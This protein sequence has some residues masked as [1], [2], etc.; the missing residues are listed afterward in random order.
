[1]VWSDLNTARISLN[2]A[3][4]CINSMNVFVQHSDVVHYFLVIMIF[5][6]ANTTAFHMPYWK[7]SE[8]G[9]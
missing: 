7:F 2:D 6:C 1:V 4:I 8:W 3:A 5:C 9:R